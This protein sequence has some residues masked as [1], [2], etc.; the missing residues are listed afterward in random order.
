MAASSLDRL[1]P[2]MAKV[3]LGVGDH[4]VG[5]LNDEDWCDRTGLSNGP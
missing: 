1:R 4:E 2:A 3:C 5:S